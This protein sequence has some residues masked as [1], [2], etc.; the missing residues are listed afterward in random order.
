MSTL[1]EGLRNEVKEECKGILKIEQ[2]ESTKPLRGSFERKNEV[3]YKTEKS[4]RT[5]SE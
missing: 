5:F 2:R 4:T 1:Q 3:K